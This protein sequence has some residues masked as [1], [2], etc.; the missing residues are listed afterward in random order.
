V[1]RHEAA[2]RC[3]FGHQSSGQQADMT[4]TYSVSVSKKRRNLCPTVSAFHFT[5]VLLK[6]LC[7]HFNKITHAQMCTKRNYLQPAFTDGK[8][9]QCVISDKKN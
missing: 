2:I 9:G 7:A 5:A 6:L 3:Y 8:S 4:A 1:E